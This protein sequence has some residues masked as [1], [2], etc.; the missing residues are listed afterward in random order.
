MQ[1]QIIVG[2]AQIEGKER[3]GWFMGHFIEPTDPRSTS[4]LEIKWAIHPAG[5]ARS[6]WA[7]A[8]DVTTISILIRGKFCV[9]FPNQ[10]VLLSEPGDYVLWLPGVAH[11][12]H[13]EADSTILTVRYPSLA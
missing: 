2:N 9:Q 1:P 3:R 8:A 12:W 13:A 7:P 6:Q 5:D 11:T 10:D 4:A